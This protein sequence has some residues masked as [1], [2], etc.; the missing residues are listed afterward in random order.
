MGINTQA[1]CIALMMGDVH[2]G[3]FLLP[4]GVTTHFPIHDSMAFLVHSISGSWVLLIHPL[5]QS[6]FGWFAVNH[7]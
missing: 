7:G 2:W 5:A 4:I 3:G 1:T 6:I